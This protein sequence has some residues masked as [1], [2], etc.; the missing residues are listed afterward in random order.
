MGGGPSGTGRSRP[1][2]RTNRPEGR[3]ST[4]AAV[5]SQDTLIAPSLEVRAH[6][7][8]TQIHLWIAQLG[9]PDDVACRPPNDRGVFGDVSV[10]WWGPVRRR[11]EH[12]CVRDATASVPRQ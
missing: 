12:G 7:S 11:G 4:P 8:H 2:P 5:G 9:V 6:G 3:R 10:A 1:R